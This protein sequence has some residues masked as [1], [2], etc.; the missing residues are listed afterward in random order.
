MDLDKAKYF[1]K[2]LYTIWDA[3]RGGMVDLVVKYVDNGD[4]DIDQ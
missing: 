3:A 4:Y 2:W 1:M